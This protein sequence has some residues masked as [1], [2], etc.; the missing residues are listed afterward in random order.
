MEG[1]YQG[2]SVGRPRKMDSAMLAMAAKLYYE[3]GMPV[4]EVADAMHVSHMTVWRAL[5]RV[6]VADVF[7]EVVS[8]NR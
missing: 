1:N 2:Y 4:R 8:Y 5:S 6:S 3:E 7:P